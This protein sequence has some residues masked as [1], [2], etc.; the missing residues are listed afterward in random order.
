MS[1]LFETNCL[2][3]STFLYRGVI[4]CKYVYIQAAITKQYFPHAQDRLKLKININ[5]VGD[6]TRENKG[7]LT[8]I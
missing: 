4:L 8:P 1:V 6:R 7:L 2:L 3:N 5:P